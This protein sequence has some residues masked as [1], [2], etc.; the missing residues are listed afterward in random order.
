MAIALAT[1]T[2][3]DPPGHGDLHAASAHAWHPV[4]RSADLVEGGWAQVRLLGRTWTVSR[5]GGVLA[6]DPPASGV[7]ERHGLVRL[8]PAEPRDPPLPVPEAGDPRFV[9]TWLPPSRTAAPAAAFADAVLA[10]G[11]RVSAAPGRRVTCTTRAPFE[12][13]LRVEDSGSGAVR[14]LLVVLQPED[15][16]STRVHACLLLGGARL[17]DR[18]TVA[19][20][21]A[22]A[23][24][25]LAGL[26]APA[27][28]PA[29]LVLPPEPNTVALLADPV[30]A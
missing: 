25:L 14:T 9:G 26:P 2:L 13:R 20:E 21:V 16:D 8:A 7:E 17:P 3:G 15:D 5:T 18:D 4:A 28:G 6:A 19:A 30:R 23:Q 24:Q 29:G 12:L 10:R 11:H 27:D 1:A 22:A